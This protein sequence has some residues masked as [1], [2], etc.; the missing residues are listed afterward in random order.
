MLQR[1]VAEGIHRI[2]EADTN[3]YLVEDGAAL[4]VVDAGFPASWGTLER[5]TG[6]LGRSLG[7]IVAVV[8]THGHFDHVGFAERARTE[9]GVPVHVHEEEVEVAR[10][11][12]H[13]D[14]ERS[15]LPYGRHPGFVK[16]FAL[17][18]AHGALWVKGVEEPETYV[19]HDELDV[20]GRPRV[21][22]T[23]GH[24]H[25]HC[26]LHFADRG[27]VIA[28]DAFVLRDPYTGREGP[29]IVAG[30]ATAD[31]ERALASVDH[32]ATLDAAVALTGHGPP[33]TGGLAEA[34]ARAR[35]A[36]PA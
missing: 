19:D 8:L 17:M 7:D 26:A 35:A 31:S 9:L 36:G 12:W 21:V 5:V 4:T 23:P 28:G 33:W 6:E 20:P 15:R 13:Y 34:A 29:C 3:W 32:L 10:R 16:T 27:A 30:A 24:T 11:P 1:D 2:E 25:G 14:H 22:P 18:G